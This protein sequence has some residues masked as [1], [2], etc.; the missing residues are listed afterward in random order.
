MDAT[1]P[2]AGL[3][4]RRRDTF[5]ERVARIDAALTALI[6][7]AAPDESRGIAER[8]AHQLAGALGMF[9]LPVGSEL[10]LV[11]EAALAAGGVPDATRAAEWTDAV[12]RLRVMITTAPIADATGAAASAVSDPSAPGPDEPDDEPT[13][14]PLVVVASE[15]PEL[16]ARLVREAVA[17][18][19][20]A[21]AA[22]SA[23][24]AARLT[25][26]R[27]DSVVLVDLDRPGGDLAGLREV[28]PGTVKV[29]LA[30]DAGLAAR[31][32][33]TRQDMSLYLDRGAAP[34]DVIAAVDDLVDRHG[35]QQARAV[36]VDDDPA[37]HEVLAAL[38]GPHGVAL[39][40]VSDPQRMWEC[41]T[42]VRPDLLILDLDIPVYSGLDLCRAVRSDPR[43]ADLPVLFLTATRDR[44]VLEEI[45]ASGAD[46]YVPKPI[47]GAEL[48][49]RVRNRL[50]RARLMR[51]LA[52]RDP[53]THIANRRKARAEIVRCIAIAQRH[54]QP[55]SLAMIDL[56]H[57]KMINDELGHATGDA[58]LRALGGLLTRAFRQE[59]VVGRWGGEEF[60]VCLYG[61]ERADAQASIQELL[62]RLHELPLTAADGTPVQAGFSA[63]VATF[64]TDAVDFEAL[65]RAADAALYAAK[66]AGRGRVLTA[67]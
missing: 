33:A 18:G 45:F 64:P 24:D 13:G 41:L 11:L 50:G 31:V 1:N 6:A 44:D 54:R 20:A 57:F 12:Q 16:T 2:L 36:V 65:Y 59:D 28:G 48:L 34:A 67:G 21:Q 55:V 22:R 66:R 35:P 29:A 27:R 23:A 53:L 7:G 26:G 46:D 61:A 25:G 9:G 60:I 40:G 47:V 19:L 5:L 52:D 15:D 63:G 49:G 17:V 14:Q 30:S 4:L 38:L 32:Q 8:E 39:T 42:E 10:A 43:Y 62:S 56:D 58:V 3:W 37:I 51:Q